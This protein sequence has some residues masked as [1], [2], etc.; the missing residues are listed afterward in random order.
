MFLIAGIFVGNIHEKL[1]ESLDV[2][3][4]WDSYANIFRICLII[5]IY[6]TYMLFQEKKDIYTCNRF[7]DYLIRNLLRE[8]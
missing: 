4:Q 3:V 5:C 7:L 6:S 8:K 2:E 1:H